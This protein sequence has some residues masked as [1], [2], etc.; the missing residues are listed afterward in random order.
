MSTNASFFIH[1]W[2]INSFLP[3]R[4]EVLSILHHHPRP[5]VFALCEAKTSAKPSYSLKARGYTYFNFPYKR[6]SSGLLVYVRRHLP[7][8]HLKQ[9]RLREEDG[10][11]MECIEIVLAPNLSIRLVA[12]Y[13]NPSASSSTPALFLDQC[14]RI[15]EDD[16]RR[17]LLLMGDFNCRSIDFG[18][19][20]SS[21]KGNMLVH[22]CRR[23]DLTVLNARDCHGMPTY[24][25]ESVLDLAITN[26]P[27]LFHMSMH[28]LPVFSDHEP[29]TVTCSAPV[30]V[31]NQLN[32][33]PKWVMA[34][35][36]WEGY[37][38]ECFRRIMPVEGKWVGALEG[39]DAAH[40][41]QVLGEVNDAL[42]SVLSSAA[43][44]YVERA[45]QKE[46]A[47]SRYHRLYGLLVAS[48]RM[49]NRMKRA[50]IVLN[51]VTLRGDNVD[52]AKA[53]LI[54]AS[55]AYHVAKQ[56]YKKVAKE[57]REKDWLRI[58]RQVE[59][60][61]AH[62]VFRAWK[63][64]VPSSNLPMNSVTRRS[65]HQLPSSV[66][67]S[68]N[69][70]ARFYSSVMSTEPLPE[71]N[72]SAAPRP[73]PRMTRF[74]LEVA[75]FVASPEPRA[76][77]GN[78]D[79]PF[80]M[81]EVMRACHGLGPSTAP[82]PDDLPSLFIKKAP[83]VVLRV[84][85][86][87]FN[88]SWRFS[89]HPRSW[90]HANAFCIP[91][92]GPPN[93]PSSY[94]IISITSILIRCFE[95]IVKERLV[96]H[97]EARNFF[98]PNQAGF[99]HSLSTLDHL[100]LLKREVH[101]AMRKNRQLPVVFLDIVKA[102]DRVPHDRL[103]YKLYKQG[104]ISGRAWL[105]IQSFLSDRTFC[106]TQGSDKS[107]T[108]SASAGVPQGAVLSPLLFIIYINDIATGCTLPI[109]QSLFA[110]DI[111]AWPTTRLWVRS[112]YKVLREYLLHVDRWSK[113]WKL[114]FSV[115]K[116]GVVLFSHKRIPPKP[117]D[118]P[119]R[120]AGRRLPRCSKYKYL[121]HTLK[122]DL[123]YQLHYGV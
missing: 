60:K 112:Q 10:S 70:V 96:K 62:L 103:L 12:L 40:A 24:G 27:D 110:D 1:A 29:I 85:L 79:D 28:S 94:R 93:D 81:F 97:L 116:S 76:P 35:A 34:T 38:L 3:R 49:R 66:R 17:P 30:P 32:S 16:P 21:P 72:A 84:M 48:N 118:P 117:P 18:D 14:Q 69:N 25:K 119:L 100:F 37:D 77:C 33:S 7:N 80:S 67:E 39:S 45:S 73:L 71:W 53:R 23:H 63:R 90:R 42:I 61:P 47:I 6:N 91:K 123:G 83:P 59:S 41:E 106:V 101:A 74:D 75:D 107:E 68:L 104:G 46:L 22:R 11:M 99:R 120:L 121:G 86:A 55:V 8:R 102:F 44:D 89:V 15:V 82:G 5:S 78:L 105:W 9:F 95:R 58:C 109:H 65:N 87:M 122:Q 52:E 2:N 108:V 56:R 13:I 64:T 115:K 114:Q 113:K 111:A 57:Q 19:S 51:R 54:R 88:V 43:A 26:K 4:D 92:E 36:D 20:V 31:R 98:S 50:R